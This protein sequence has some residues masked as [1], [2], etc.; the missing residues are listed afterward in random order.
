MFD[1][2]VLELPNM[3]EALDIDVYEKNFIVEEKEF[4]EKAEEI[5][6]NHVNKEEIAKEILRVYFR[7]KNPLTKT[8]FSGK[9]AKS[10]SLKYPEKEVRGPII[11]M[12][13]ETLID[14]GI[15]LFDEE[16]AR[17]VKK[18]AR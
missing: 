12:A 4:L 2:N 9:I 13:V 1:Y 8:K 16:K 3:T 11:A 14:S 6:E 18:N 7:L 10:L 17:V 15:V 5:I